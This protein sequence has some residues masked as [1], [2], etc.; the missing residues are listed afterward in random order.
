MC[1]Y[2]AVPDGCAAGDECDVDCICYP[3]EA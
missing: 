2:L 3:E 1:D